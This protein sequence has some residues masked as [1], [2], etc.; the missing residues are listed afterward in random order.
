M[1]KVLLFVLILGIFGCGKQEKDGGA[2][3]AAKKVDIS[4]GKELF[5]SK[6]CMTCHTIGG[7]RLVGPDLKG[8]TEKREEKWLIAMITKP[9]SMLKFDPLAKKLLAEYNNVPMLQQGT[10]EAEAKEILLYLKHVK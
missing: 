10:T 7:G 5:T 3:A 6:I 9:D 8:I 1:F 2:A 4:K